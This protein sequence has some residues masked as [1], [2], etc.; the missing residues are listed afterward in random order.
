[1]VMM[2]AVGS[3]SAS[4]QVWLVC[5]A[6]GVSHCPKAPHF[7]SI[8]RAVQ[9]ARTGD[10]V[11]VWPGTYHEKGT[12][13]AGVYIDKPGIHIRGMDRNRVIVDGTNAGD[14]TPCSS[15]AAFQDTSGRNGIEVFKADGVTI[16]NLTVCNYLSGPNGEGNEIWWNGGDGSGTVG[17][18]SYGGSYLSATSTYY[19][20][21]S[22][23]MAFY[24]IFVSNA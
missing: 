18:G 11:L 23:P 19:G 2:L 12:A 14:S 15:N 7:A 16:D 8:Q 4:A 1:M 6:P 21:D 9:A 24:G 13:G 3:V 17:L 10:Y 22:A 20:G 5:N